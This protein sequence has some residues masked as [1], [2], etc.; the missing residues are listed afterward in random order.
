[1]IAALTGELRHVHED[2][3][4]LQAGPMLY[5]LLVSAA[6]MMTSHAVTGVPLQAPAEYAMRLM[7]LVVVTLAL[8][9]LPKLLALWEA[10]KSPRK[11]DMELVEAYLARSALDVYFVPSSG[12]LTTTSPVTP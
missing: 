11:I 1:M 4:H 9:Y 5:E 8:L 12:K 2:R 3:I 10:M 6:D 7:L